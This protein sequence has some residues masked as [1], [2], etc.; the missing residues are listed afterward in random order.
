M[1]YDAV[2]A[3]P[4]GMRF[5][6]Q[7]NLMKPSR[8]VNTVD[9]PQDDEYSQPRAI[10]ARWEMGEWEGGKGGMDHSFQSA[11]FGQGLKAE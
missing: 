2:E 9:G 10:G 3:S 1:M 5:A 4:S 6:I 7:T 8:V 11:S